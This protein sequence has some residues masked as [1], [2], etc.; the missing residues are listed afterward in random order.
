MNFRLAPFSCFVFLVVVWLFA[1]CVGSLDFLLVKQLIPYSLSVS[2]L[3]VGVEKH[4]RNNSTPQKKETKK[5]R[6]KKWG[7][8]ITRHKGDEFGI[9]NSSKAAWQ[10]KPFLMRKQTLDRFSDT[11]IQKL[12][13]HYINRVRKKNRE[14]KNRNSQGMQLKRKVLPRIVTYCMVF[15]KCVETYVA[16]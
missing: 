13:N 2:N 10:K 4:K 16:Y 8:N 12:H 7:I 6:S 3:F 9:Y 15:Y 11:L 5:Q 1:F 14:R